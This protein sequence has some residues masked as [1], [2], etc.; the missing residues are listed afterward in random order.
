MLKCQPFWIRTI[1]LPQSC[2][3]VC[4]YVY[5]IFALMKYKRKE[6]EIGRPCMTKNLD[7][8]I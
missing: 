3:T 5:Q 4:T 8:N 1:V 7:I 2:K 6:R